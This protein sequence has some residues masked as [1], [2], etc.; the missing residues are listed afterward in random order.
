M[1]RLA[2]LLDVAGVPDVIE[3]QGED[4]F[5]RPIYA[6]RDD[7]TVV[8]G[9]LVMDNIS[10]MS[11]CHDLLMLG[12]AF[13]KV[14]SS[15]K[16]KAI[17]VRTTAFPAVSNSSGSSSVEDVSQKVEA[18]PTEFVKEE[19]LKSDRPE[20]GSAK[21]VVSGGR[22]LKSADNFKLIYTLADKI[23]AGGKIYLAM[24]IH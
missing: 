12:N 21:F 8:V 10:F 4:T 22:A 2:A 9:A 14:K 5:V 15:D 19:I 11:V 17:T 23:G 20:L 24:S 18:G 6:G 7:I 3:I 16:I 13:A 1:P